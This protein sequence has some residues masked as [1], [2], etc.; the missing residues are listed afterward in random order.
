[1]YINIRQQ[2]RLLT[3]SLLT[4]CAAGCVNLKP[5]PDQTKLYVLAAGEAPTSVTD[6][7][8]LLYV[9]RPNLPLYL[10]GKHLTYSR[11]NGEAVSIPGARWAESFEEGVARGLASQINAS[12]KQLRASYFPW[13][14]PQSVDVLRVNFYQ[15]EAR[16]DGSFAV[17]ADWSL[18]PAGGGDGIRGRLELLN[19]SWIVV[20]AESYVH[21]C[22]QILKR[23]ADDIV[24]HLE[25]P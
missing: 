7:G 25:R 8:T 22:D 14:R 19:I 20:S 15:F 16:A 6:D 17:S 2:F 24:Q 21:A 23:L 9:E 5:R 10:N 3:L 12:A 4:L 1:M 11:D 13:L 18:S